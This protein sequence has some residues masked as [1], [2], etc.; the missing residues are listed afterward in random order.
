MNYQSINQSIIYYILYI[1]YYIS[2]YVLWYFLFLFTGGRNEIVQATMARLGDI[3]RLQC[4]QRDAMDP[5]QHHSRRSHEVLQRLKYSC[6]HDQ[7]DLHDNLHTVHI[8]GELVPRQIRK[9]NYIFALFSFVWFVEY[10]RNCDRMTL[11][12]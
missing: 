12:G 9:Y 5:I 6:Q 10:L 7:H 11:P 3:C 4:E 1:I 8:S 2:V